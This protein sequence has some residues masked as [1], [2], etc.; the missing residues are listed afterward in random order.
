MSN[1]TLSPTR[2]I[3]AL[4]AAGVLGGGAAAWTM[5]QHAHATPAAVTTFS[6]P[7]PIEVVTAIARR[8][9]CALA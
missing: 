1:L 5:G 3:L 6:A 4:L 8:R 7:G 9:L 2:L